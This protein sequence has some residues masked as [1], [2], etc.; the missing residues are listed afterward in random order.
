MRET[1]SIGELTVRL[2][3]VRARARRALAIRHRGWITVISISA[4][5]A[6][7]A[8]GIVRAAQTLAGD[9][10]ALGGVSVALALLAVREVVEAG[11]A[12]V[13]LASP[14]AVQAL[15]FSVLLLA[16]LALIHCSSSVT[17]AHLAASMGKVEEA[18]GALVASSASDAFSALALATR[19][20]T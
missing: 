8:G 13:A 18:R 15:A 14:D 16:E 12:A 17:V 19:G 4:T 7:R 11:L 20:I 6:V 3:P 10:V 1:A 5:L 9:R 2:W